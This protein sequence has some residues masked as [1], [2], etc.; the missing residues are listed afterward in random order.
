MFQ[1]GI[2]F[3]KTG[4]SFILEMFNTTA[5][6]A[7]KAPNPSSVAI[8]VKSYEDLVSDLLKP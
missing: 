7:D 6:E 8:T 3:F 4:L 5:F 1:T 2:V